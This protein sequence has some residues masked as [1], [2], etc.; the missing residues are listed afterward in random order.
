MIY[1]LAEKVDAWLKENHSNQ[2]EEK[3]NE[4]RTKLEE[5]VQENRQMRLSLMDTQT[6]VALMRNDLVQMRGLYEAK[7]KELAY[8]REKVLEMIQEHEFVTRQV[9]ALQ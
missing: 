3:L 1:S 5:T 9:H 4:F 8:E 6:T 2:Q 7:C